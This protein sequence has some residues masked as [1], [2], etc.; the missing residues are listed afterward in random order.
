MI[1]NPKT[2]ELIHPIR[3][4]TLSAGEVCEAI[5]QG[6]VCACHSKSCPNCVVRDTIARENRVAR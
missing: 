6:I 3:R 1:F 5:A 4:R 2:R